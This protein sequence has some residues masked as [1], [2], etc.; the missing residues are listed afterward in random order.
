MN[1]KF[2][3]NK[4]DKLFHQVLCNHRYADIWKEVKNILTG[5]NTIN[6]S[7]LNNSPYTDLSIHFTNNTSSVKIHWNGFFLF[8]TCIFSKG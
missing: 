3:V 2:Q 6:C 1:S 7:K 5:S 4:I 8:W